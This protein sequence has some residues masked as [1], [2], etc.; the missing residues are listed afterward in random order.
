MVSAAYFY[1]DV[2]N[3][4]QTVSSAGTIFDL[5][6]PEDLAAFL[7]TQTP[8]QQDWVLGTTNGSPGIYSI[9]QFQDAPGGEIKGF[10]LSYQQ[11]LTFLPWYFKNLGVQANYTKLSS[12]LA[13][14]LDPGSTTP[15]VTPQT[16]QDGPFLG[17]SPKSA[18]FTLYYDT[19]RWSARVSLAYRDQ[20]VT[21]YPIASG[22]C[23]PGACDTPL[24][25]DFIGSKA[26]KNVDAS[27]TYNLSEHFVLSLEALNL[28]NQADER[29][30][31]QNDPL[32]AQYSNTGRQY[33]AGFRFEY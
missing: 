20:Y 30:V 12:Q 1:K 31:Y 14:I 16:T 3:Y 17:A 25:N 23:A 29:W 4:P 24:V 33:F 21:T 27:F 7:E 18:N 13:Y 10:E 26:T 32:V 28:T 22:S 11:N 19:D 2:S 5:L 9:K 8:Q 15:P 6:S